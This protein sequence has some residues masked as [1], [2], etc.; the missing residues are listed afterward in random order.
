MLKRRRENLVRQPTPLPA[1][2]DEYYLPATIQVIADDPKLMI[3]GEAMEAIRCGEADAGLETIADYNPQLA[4]KITERASLLA[5]LWNNH[6]ATRS[7]TQS[8]RGILSRIRH[9]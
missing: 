7:R 4:S 8:H 6:L 1:T 3:P 9:N 2:A 5:E